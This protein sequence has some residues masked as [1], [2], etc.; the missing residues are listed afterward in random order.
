MLL[1]EAQTLT[2]L[3]LIFVRKILIL[4]QK[5]PLLNRV[6]DPPRLINFTLKIMLRRQRIINALQLIS[7][8]L[9]KFREYATIFFNEDAQVSLFFIL[10]FALGIS[11]VED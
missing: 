3:L 6:N 1:A 5:R 11:D 10:A 8:A 7:E 4:I 9:V 2:M